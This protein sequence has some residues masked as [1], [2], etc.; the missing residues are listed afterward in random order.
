MRAVHPVVMPPKTGSPYSADQQ[1]NMHL[2]S[3]T[4]NSSRTLL[5]GKITTGSVEKCL[6]LSSELQSGWAVACLQTPGCWLFAP[7]HPRALRAAAQ[8]QVTGSWTPRKTTHFCLQ[9]LPAM[10]QKLL[11]SGSRTLSRAQP[12]GQGCLDSPAPRCRRLAGGHAHSSQAR[13]SSKTAG[14]NY[15][16]ARCPHGARSAVRLPVARHVTHGCLP[17]GLLGSGGVPI[18]PHLAGA[19]ARRC[20]GAP[21]PARARAAAA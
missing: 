13:S 21:R 10:R 19:R 1:T 14:S 8:Q 18:R 16:R 7:R 3:R 12:S 20:A 9:P 2:S 11:C 5:Y 6:R 17:A 15:T 4:P